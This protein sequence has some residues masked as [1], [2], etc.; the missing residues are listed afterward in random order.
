MAKGN[1]RDYLHREEVK[2]KKYFYVLRPILAAKWIEKYNTI[3]PVDF[4]D[5][6]NDILLAGELKTAIQTL[7]QRK[8]AGEELNLEPKIVVINQFL[9]EEIE[10]LEEYAK[11]IKVDIPNPT[12]RLNQLF[13]ETLK[14]VW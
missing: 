1:Y 5:L 7:L 4:T 10:H 14:E 11:G 3:P 13:R 6:L 8:I 12:E 9:N 2:I